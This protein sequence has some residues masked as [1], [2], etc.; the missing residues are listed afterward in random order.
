MAQPADSGGKKLIG[1]EPTAW[2]RWAT[3]LNDIMA[4]APLDHEFQWVT[5]RAD[6]LVPA[7]SE[8]LGD[9]L[10]A[11]ELCLRY[12]AFVGVRLRAYHALAEEKFNQP[13]YPVLVVM[14]PPPEGVE[15]LAQYETNFLGKRGLQE[16]KVIKLW[17]VQAEIV[18]DTPIRTLLP[19]VPL[20]AGGAEESMVR[21]AAQELRADE[22]LADL[23]PLLAV[24]AAYV[25]DPDVVKDLVRWDM[26]L[27]REN[28]FAEE[29]K[30][31]G[32]Q[33]GRRDVVLETLDIRFGVVPLP[34]QEAVRKVADDAAL[35]ELLKSAISCRTIEEFQAS[36]AA[37]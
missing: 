3:G 27:V 7:H 11:S 33:E 29:L 31:E 17:E 19:Y 6:A 32:R 15:I 5:R 13:T 26:A 25:M 36:V 2:A 34:V 4:G 30:Q 37:S 12:N 9:F 22:E 14:L 20:M 24:M 21:R 28:P 8:S 18:F 16:F 10:I 35:H 23:A 1:L